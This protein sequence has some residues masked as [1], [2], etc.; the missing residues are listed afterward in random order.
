[1]FRAALAD[2][3][4]GARSAAEAVA[5]R[6]MTAGRLPAFE[7]NVPIVRRGVVIYVADVLWR[8]L[9]AVLEIDSREYH[10]SETAWKRRRAATTRS[11]GRPGGDA[12]SRRPMIS[13]PRRAGSAEVEEWLRARADELSV[14]LAPGHR[15]RY[16]PARTG[17]RPS[18]SA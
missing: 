12:L 2:A 5:A 18:S 13:G 17:R 8:A 3:L 16:A 11:P 7:L 9:R 6:R 10:F 1:M 4:D 14:A 15:G